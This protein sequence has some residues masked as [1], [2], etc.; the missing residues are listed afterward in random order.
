MNGSHR[1]KKK[2]SKTNRRKHRH[3][4]KY[5]NR[6]THLQWSS[7][8]KTLTSPSIVNE[9][10]PSSSS[11]DDQSKPLVP[12]STFI[13][14]SKSTILHLFSVIKPSIHHTEKPNSIRL[15]V[16]TQNLISKFSKSKLPLSSIHSTDHSI[17]HHQINTINELKSLLQHKN[18]HPSLN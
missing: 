6:S 5:T 4:K 9:N 3:R 1:S 8:L 7:S 2:S 13:I 11:I 10:Q 14:H 18:I 12:K 17:Q 16:K 15:H